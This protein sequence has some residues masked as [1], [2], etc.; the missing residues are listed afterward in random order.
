MYKSLKY[1]LLSSV[2]LL[3]NQVLAMSVL[4]VTPASIT[5]VLAP[6]SS[7]TL[8]FTV[9]NNMSVDL[10]VTNIVPFSDMDN[11]NFSIMSDTCTGTWLTHNNMDSCSVTAELVAANISTFSQGFFD[12]NAC[13]DGGANCSSSEFKVIIIIDPA[14]PDDLIFYGGFD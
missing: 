13:I 4:E 7:T 2:F 12:I 8:D 5:V 11:L 9:S 3:S 1:C 14:Q 10:F 6:G